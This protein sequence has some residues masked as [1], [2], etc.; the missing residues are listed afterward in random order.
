MAT[1]PT[2]LLT[3]R[4]RELLVR[5]AAEGAGQPGLALAARLRREYPPDLVA[6]AMAQTELRQTARGPRMI[7]PMLPRLYSRPFVPLLRR[8]AAARPRLCE[9]RRLR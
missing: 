8:D 2:A 7:P 4:G 6:L 5:L 3:P 1:D 9:A